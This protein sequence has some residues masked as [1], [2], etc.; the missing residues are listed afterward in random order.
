MKKIMILS[1]CMFGTVFASQKEV[2]T[3]EQL[4]EIN[5]GMASINNKP[6][7]HNIEARCGAL[8]RQLDQ[9]SKELDEADDTKTKSSLSD[10]RS[11]KDCS[12]VDL[13]RSVASCNGNVDDIN[14]FELEGMKKPPLVQ[15][16]SRNRVGIRAGVGFDRGLASVYIQ[17]KISAALKEID[18][19]IGRDTGEPGS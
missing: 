6:L 19:R 16:R 12:W 9:L 17:P 7:D 5:Q 18:T 4:V 14:P 10:C 13:Q 3:K 15:E 1:L 8:I 2:L 11:A